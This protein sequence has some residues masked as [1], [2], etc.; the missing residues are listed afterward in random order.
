MF[1]KI[2]SIFPKKLKEEDITPYLLIGEEKGI[3]KLVDRFYHYMGT[4]SEAKRCRDLHIGDIEPIKE[5]LFMFLSGW[6][7]GP[8]LYI[9]KFGHPKM[10]RRHFPFEIG[11]IEKDEWLLCMRKAMDDMKLIAEFDQYLWKSF[12]D[13][14]EHMRNKD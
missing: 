4:L 8:S 11:I 9:E 12:T 7:G 3:R 10:R 2:L 6:L 13:F 1:S 5:K 14:S